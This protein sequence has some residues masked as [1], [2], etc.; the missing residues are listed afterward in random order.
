MFF[1]E[2]PVCVISV[3]VVK[4]RLFLLVFVVPYNEKEYIF[5]SVNCNVEFWCPSSDKQCGYKRPSD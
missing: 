4:R 3:A 5:I 2:Y 1:V